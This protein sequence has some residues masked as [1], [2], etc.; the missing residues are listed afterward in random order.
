MLI[1]LLL[2]GMNRSMKIDCDGYKPL[3][4]QRW[5]KADYR[6]QSS[7]ASVS[8]SRLYFVLC[9]NHAA[10]QII[11]YKQQFEQQQRLSYAS[12]MNMLL[13]NFTEHIVATRMTRLWI[14]ETRLI[15]I[16]SS[17]ANEFQA[18]AISST[19][20]VQATCEW[21]YWSDLRV[22]LVITL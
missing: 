18:N 15:Q 7:T 9:K 10:Y 22:L 5:G 6:N 12:Y 16:N 13:T 17:F 19:V 20:A 1:K 3:C 2:S 11:H 14:T 21:D 8:S 4:F